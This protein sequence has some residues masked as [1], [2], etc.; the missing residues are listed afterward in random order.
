MNHGF[1]KVASAVPRVKVADCQYNAAHIENIITQA[2][3]QDVQVVCFPEL[4]L[5]GT[6]CGDLFHNEFLLAQ[7]MDAL[8]DVVEC[9]EGMNIFSIVGLPVE[10]DNNVYNCAAVVH[11]GEVVSLH[12][13]TCVMGGEERW[14][15][16]ANELKNRT[17]K[18]RGRDVV[19]GNDVVVGFGK[20]KFTVEVGADLWMADT[21]GVKQCVNGAHLVFNAASWVE[22]CGK[23]AN[24]EQ[25]VKVVSEKSVCGYVLSAAGYGESTTGGVYAGMTMIAENGEVLKKGERF[26]IE[27]QLVISD[28]DI[29]IINAERRKNRCCR[30]VGESRLV[31]CEH[32][33][34]KYI[35]I[36]RKINAY[37]FIPSYDVCD[38]WC[39]DMFNIQAMGLVKRMKHTGL[40]K[41]VIGV[42][43][44]LDSTLALLVCV[45]VC[46][47]MG[48]GRENVVA[49]TMP[50]FGTSTRTYENAIELIK[51]LGCDFR[52]ISIKDA[53][54]QHFED[55]GHDDE[56]RDAVYENAQARERTQV[57]MDIANGC[58]GIVVGTGDLSELALGWATFNGDH[59]CM[60]GVNAGIPKT[61]VRFLVEYKAHSGVFEERVGEILKDVV[62]TPVSPELL[63]SMEDGSIAQ[64]T[65]DLVGPYELHDFFI[66]NTLRYGYKPEKM[67]FVASIAFEKQYSEDVVKHWYGVFVKRFFAQQFK[68]NCVPDA[69]KV[70]CVGL[71]P[72][73]DWKMASD[74]VSRNWL[75]EID[76]VM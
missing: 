37:P 71:S 26:V 56:V 8:W 59:M 52:E 50:G 5:T 63:P 7:A 66:Y 49:I 70:C 58:G 46:D 34:L 41:L 38:S 36:D 1:I 31:E 45:D 72:H 40:E 67:L 4:S 27:E 39:S 54:I 9:T 28:I 48:L 33:E 75:E 29:D 17:V 13:K 11:R 23:S 57:L 32:E 6:T 60:Y 65:E 14:F 69:P 64:K 21:V 73:S 10:I 20:V 3:E 68:R 62:D 18:M 76:G 24:V 2:N 19:I 51:G 42:S 30:N 55:I 61:L 47:K 25:V 22:Y 15:S 74:A 35:S 53:C 44:G 16:S 12:V 43:G